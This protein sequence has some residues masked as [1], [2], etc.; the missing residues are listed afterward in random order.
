MVPSSTSTCPFILRAK[1]PK[2]ILS[3]GKVKIVFPYNTKGLVIL[4]PMKLQRTFNVI[5]SIYFWMVHKC[6]QDKAIFP[7]T[8]LDFSLYTCLK[9]IVNSEV[10]ADLQC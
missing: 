6:N 2:D 1:I 7:T 9:K 5:S 8:M 4:F 10:I 3:E